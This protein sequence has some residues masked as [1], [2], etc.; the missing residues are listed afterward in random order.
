[1][2]HCTTSAG[3]TQGTRITAPAMRCPFCP[4]TAP[5]AGHV[6]PL[7]ASSLQQ[8]LLPLASHPAGVAQTESKLRIAASRSRGKRG[9]PQTAAL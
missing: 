7:M 5:G 8:D 3:E 2:H 1:M 4:S 6:S 9:P